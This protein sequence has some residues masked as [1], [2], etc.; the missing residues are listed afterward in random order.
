MY[1]QCLLQPLA[2]CSSLCSLW[3]PPGRL[4]LPQLNQQLRSTMPRAPLATLVTIPRYAMVSGATQG[5][6]RLVGD[7]VGTAQGA[8]RPTRPIAMQAERQRLHY[9]DMLMSNPFGKP[10]PAP[11]K[12][13]AGSKGN[14][15]GFRPSS[16]PRWS[17]LQ[18]IKGRLKYKVNK[19]CPTLNIASFPATV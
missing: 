11:S 15:N 17:A 18:A 8:G 1:Q 9:F 14:G 16:P 5:V 10:T 2:A 12:R 13:R 19:P 3:G 7:G 6:P 4:Q